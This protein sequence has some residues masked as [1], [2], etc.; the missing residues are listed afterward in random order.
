M[1][2]KQE[3][4]EA[5]EGA[6]KAGEALKG[7]NGVDYPARDVRLSLRE[8]LRQMQTKVY[9]LMRLVV[10]LKQHNSFLQ[11]VFDSIPDEVL[12]SHEET[13]RAREVER[14]FRETLCDQYGINIEG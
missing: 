10:A 9:N 3:V 8:N 7:G 4:R 2:E 13:K 1:S 14:N 11:K 5:R 12:N 6:K